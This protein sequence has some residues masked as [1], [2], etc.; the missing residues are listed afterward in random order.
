M[1]P[2]KLENKLLDIEIQDEINVAP[3]R[4]YIEEWLQRRMDKL[5]DE[6][7]QQVGW[8]PVVVDENKKNAST[9]KYQ[10][11]LYVPSL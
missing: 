3:M 2:R 10:K 4:S 11:Y 6:G 7:K 5:T 8:I 9:R 1:D